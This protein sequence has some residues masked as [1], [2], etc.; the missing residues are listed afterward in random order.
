M[1]RSPCFTFIQSALCLLAAHYMPSKSCLVHFLYRTKN[2]SSYSSNSPMT[3]TARVH[4]YK[5]NISVTNLLVS[6]TLMP[7]NYRGIVDI[8]SP[9]DRKRHLST[10]KQLSMELLHARILDITMERTFRVLIS[11]NEKI[12][13]DSERLVVDLDNVCKAISLDICGLGILSMDFDAVTGLRIK[14]I[15]LSEIVLN[16]VVR[17]LHQRANLAPFAWA[18]NKVGITSSDLVSARTH[19]KSVLKSLIREQCHPYVDDPLSSVNIIRTLL[20]DYGTDLTP[21]NEQAIGADVYRGMLWSNMFLSSALS[22]VFF[23]LLQN[24]DVREKATQ[25]IDRVWKATHGKIQL[26][27]LSQLLY[28]ECVVKESLRLHP[29]CAYLV[30]ESKES[31]KVGN[32]LFSTATQFRISVI[33]LHQDPLIW[34]DPSAFLPQRWEKTDANT[35]PFYPFGDDPDLVVQKLALV[36]IKAAVAVFLRHISFEHAKK[37]TADEVPSATHDI[38]ASGAVC[39]LYDENSLLECIATQRPLDS[40]Q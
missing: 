5:S 19:F 33:D 31:V 21:E 4:L 1:V 39:K 3:K 25:E 9:E 12:R 28:V 29:V 10:V 16:K 13:T 38:D 27:T 35:L 2:L 24:D 6:P 11:W 18:Y 22:F 15:T 26:D 34:N 30:K 8:P 14:Q 40:L 36:P 32:Y 17:F 23:E 20:K 7:C 37:D